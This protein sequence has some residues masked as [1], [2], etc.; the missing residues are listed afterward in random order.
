[1]KAIDLTER[2]GQI[3]EMARVDFARNQ[4]HGSYRC[5]MGHPARGVCGTA[6]CRWQ[7][8]TAAGGACGVEWGVVDLAHRSPLEG[9]T[10][11]LS[12]LSNL[13]PAFSEMAEGRSFRSDFTGAGRGSSAAGKA[14]PER[15]SHRRLLRG[16]EKGGS[17]VGKTKRGKGTKIMA[18]TDGHGVPVA[19]HVASA[20]PHETR[21]VEATLD[22]H[23]APQLPQKLLGDLAYDSDPLDEK[24]KEKYGVDLIAPHKS[25]RRKPPTQDRRALRRFCRRWKVER[26]FA[27]LHNFRRLV[28]RWE[29]K[30]SNFLGM[31]QLAC[32]L[33]LMRRY[34]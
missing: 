31:L 34:F 19:V 27:W 23:F 24:L 5:P 18:V 25:N 30:E 1:M 11:S 33:I 21:L 14:R 22:N 9:L 2:T 26:F 16:S 13:S 12:T 32:I 28:T 6:A 4:R 29:Y 3:V 7:G 15:R 10:R 8:A 17:A 20:S